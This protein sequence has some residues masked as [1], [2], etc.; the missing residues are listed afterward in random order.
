MLKYC[1]GEDIHPYKCKFLSCTEDEQ[2]KGGRKEEHICQLFWERLYHGH[3]H[4]K[5]PILPQCEGP[6]VIRMIAE[7]RGSF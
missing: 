4:P 6:V 1:E 3:E 2:D 7:T 5:L